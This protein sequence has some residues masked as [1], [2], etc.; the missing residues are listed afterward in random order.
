MFVESPFLSWLIVT[1]LLF[2]FYADATKVGAMKINYNIKGGK[3][4]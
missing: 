3:E 4:R 2:V 1:E